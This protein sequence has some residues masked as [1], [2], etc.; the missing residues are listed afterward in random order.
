MA[1]SPETT[2]TV[3]YN[4]GKM[5]CDPE[6]VHCFWEV[7]GQEDIRWTFKGFPAEIKFVGV[8]FL[9]FVP[10][11][12]AQGVPGFIDSPPYLGVGPV[13]SAGQ[14]GLPDL[15]TYGNLHKKGYFCYS[16]RFYDGNMVQRC[17]LDPGGTNDPNPPESPNP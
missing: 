5:S 4:N 6:W 17:S 9:N 10:P 13:D 3:T 12:Y 15:K 14:V 8:S 1:A 7:P 11:K 2:V 16:L